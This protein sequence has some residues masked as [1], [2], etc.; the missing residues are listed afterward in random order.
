MERTEDNPRDLRNA[1]GHFATGITVVT[2]V[3]EDVTYGMTANAF[4]SV[5]LDPPLVLVAADNR[6]QWHQVVSQSRRYGVSVLSEEQGK[7]S[8][9]FA[10]RNG[11]EDLEIP[12]TWQ[13]GMP[14]L[15]GA[16]AHFV[17]K[18]V[19]PHPAGDHTLHIA[20]IEYLDY[21]EGAPL[22]FYTGTYEGLDVWETS[23][24]W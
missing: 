7:F 13:K 20:E 1:L 16:I 22:L 19:D 9:H 14:L 15:E 10:G 11:Q 2:T 6:T 23:F 8:D 4:L 18:V 5:S 12:F 21:R 3:H 17:C 24:F